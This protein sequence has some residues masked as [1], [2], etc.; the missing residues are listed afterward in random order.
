MIDWRILAASFTAIILVSSVA[1][2][3]FGTGFFSDILD[4]IGDWL[5]TSPFS[6]FFITPTA[7]THAVELTLYPETIELSP[8]SKINLSTEKSKLMNFKGKMT[9]DFNSQ[10]IRLEESGTSLIFEI[11]I[12]EVEVT[13][14]K[15]SSLSV[16]N[17]S[18]RVSPD[19]VSEK[20]SAQMQNFYGSVLINLD[21]LSFKGNVSKITAKIG[22][23]TWELK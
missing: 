1:L 17:V 22:E 4:N 11:P 6:G 18:L 13:N 21:S 10:I 16:D 3:G 12:E 20:G 5:G 14:V 15:L 2:G 19:I 23:N 9:I 7:K 8:D